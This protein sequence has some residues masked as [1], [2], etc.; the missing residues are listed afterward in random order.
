MAVAIVAQATAIAINLVCFISDLPG[1]AE[2][3]VGRTTRLTW[4][5]A[6]GSERVL[7]PLEFVR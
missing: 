3:R 4:A 7:Q 2:V 5:K 6:E 1:T